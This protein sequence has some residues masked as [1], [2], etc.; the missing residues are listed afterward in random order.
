MGPTSYRVNRHPTPPTHT[1]Y[2]HPLSTTPPPFLINILQNLTPKIQ[3]QG[4]GWGLNDKVAPTSYRLTFHRFRSIGHLIFRKWLFL[5]FDLELQGQGH[6]SKWHCVQ[7]L[8]TSMPFQVIR[9]S[10]SWYTTFAKFYTENPKVKFMEDVTTY[11][12][13]SDWLAPLSFHVNPVPRIQLSPNLTLKINDQCHNAR[14]QRW[15]HVLST[16]IYFVPTQ[17]ALLFMRYS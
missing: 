11:S 8:V 3:G 10:H 12:H 13:I 9:P 7:H 5:K 14:S 4:H 15:P 2:P 17:A 16:H 6:I 1:P